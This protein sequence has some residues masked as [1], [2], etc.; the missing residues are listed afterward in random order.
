MNTMGMR[1]LSDTQLY[2][3]ISCRQRKRSAEHG[4]ERAEETPKQN[5]MHHAT[6]DPA[7]IGSRVPGVRSCG[8]LISSL[9]LNPNGR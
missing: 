7:R 9:H 6:Q 5:G 8:L 1:S 3:K 4:A 2:E